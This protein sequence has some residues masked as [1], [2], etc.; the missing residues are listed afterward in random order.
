[1]INPNG[2]NIEDDYSATSSKID[3]HST[4]ENNLIYEILEYIFLNT[5]SKKIFIIG[6]GNSKLANNVGVKPIGIW[7]NSN[8][9]YIKQIYGLYT[10]DGLLFKCDADYTKLEKKCENK[11]VNFLSYNTNTKNILGIVEK[12]TLKGKSKYAYFRVKK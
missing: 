7:L 12:H 3:D 5:L 8:I 4:F 10:I 11:I 2:R 6:A 1:M 9:H